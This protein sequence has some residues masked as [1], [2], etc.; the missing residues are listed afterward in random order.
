MAKPVAGRTPSHMPRER[1]DAGVQRGQRSVRAGLRAGLGAEGDHVFAT[2]AAPGL[3]RVQVVFDGI[4]QGQVEADGL[5]AQMRGRQAG[6]QV[7]DAHLP[8]CVG[9]VVGAILGALGDVVVTEGRGYQVLE[10]DLRRFAHAHGM[11]LIAETLDHRHELQ[12]LIARPIDEHADAI[13]AVLILGGRPQEVAERLA[14]V[15]EEAQ[16]ESA[17]C[18]R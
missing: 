18:R 11:H 5:A 1:A 13:R 8:I 6:V 10:L 3:V 12:E 4:A 9:L 17:A 16:A 2:D 15:L 7:A 14:V